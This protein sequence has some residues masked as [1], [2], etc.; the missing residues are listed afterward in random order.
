MTSK[1]AA[2]SQP[3]SKAP[4]LEDLKPIDRSSLLKQI[5]ATMP[6]PIREEVGA[7]GSLVYV[8]GDPGE[9]VVRIAQ[10]RMT[11]SVF[12]T[13]CEGSDTPMVSPQTLVK[14]QWTYLPAGLLTRLLPEIIEVA[15]Q[16]RLA[17]YCK[18]EHCGE[19]K[20]PEWMHENGICQSCDQHN[21]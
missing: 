18:C 6:L 4:K 21:A 12:G 13:E 20:P 9:V 7:D 19:T 15:R 2:K 14:L 1:K 5:H 11:V 16:I 8:G 3:A 10:G 17:K